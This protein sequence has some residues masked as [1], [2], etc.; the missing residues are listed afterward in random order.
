MPVLRRHG[1]HGEIFMD[2]AGAEPITG[3]LL[4]SMNGWTLDMARDKVDV[5]AFGDPNKVYVQGFMDIKGTL[6][7]WWE[8]LASRPLFDV[9]MGDTP[10]GLKLVPS[11]LDSTAFYSGLAYLDASIEVAAD[12]AVSIS[13]NFA[14]AGPWAIAPAGP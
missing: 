10:C 1:M 5:T 2:P 7:G 8:A 6:K 3:T 11:S 4:A 14:A 13:G 12:G 9:A